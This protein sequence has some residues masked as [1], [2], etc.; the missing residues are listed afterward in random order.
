[1]KKLFLLMLLLSAVGFAENLV[2]DNQTSYPGKGSKMMVQWASSAKEVEEGNQAVM[3]GAKLN[4]KSLRMITHSGKNN[5]SIP[6][7]SEYFRVLIWSMNTIDPDLLTNWVEVV[8]NK[9]YT[10]KDDLLVPSVLM[11]GMGC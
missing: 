11:S 2:F 4:N 5:I 8:P 7:K 1:M 9:T 10:L 6:K 3:H